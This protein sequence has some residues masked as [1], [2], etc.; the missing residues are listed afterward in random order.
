MT[1]KHD[2]NHSHLFIMLQL[3]DLV[4]S[5]VFLTCLAAD[6]LHLMILRMVVGVHIGFQGQVDLQT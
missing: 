6:I 4:I 5:I 2:N 1:S 3:V